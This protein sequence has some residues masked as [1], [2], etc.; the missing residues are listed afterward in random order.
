VWMQLVHLL[1]ADLVWLALV[2]LS[3]A[4]LAPAAIESPAPALATPRVHG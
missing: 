4:S 1:L 3:A 2:V